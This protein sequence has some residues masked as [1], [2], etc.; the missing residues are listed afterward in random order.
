MATAV[1]LLHIATLVHDDTVDH[2]DT[3]RGHQTASNL[4]GRN[5]AVLLG[6]FLF[7]TS[8]MYVCDTN[9]IRLVRRF[10]ETITELAQG[11]L[12]EIYTAWQTGITLE[13]V[14]YT[15]LRAHET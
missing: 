12:D 15:H 5:V 10:A 8:A 1:E 9:N 3:R 6:D 14:S 2:A 4:W 11:E 13:S 7:A